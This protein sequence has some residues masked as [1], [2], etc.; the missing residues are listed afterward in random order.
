MKILLLCDKLFYCAHIRQ[1]DSV[2]IKTFLILRENCQSLAQYLKY[3]ALID[4]SANKMKTY[5]V[6][7]KYS[8]EIAAYFSLKAGLISIEN[9]DEERDEFFDTLPGF[10]LANFAVNDSYICKHPHSK[11]LGFVVFTDFISPIVEMAS[12]LI[13]AKILYVFAL[14]YDTLLTHYRQK[15]G[16]TRLDK[17]QEDKLHKRIKNDYD[18]TCIFMYMRI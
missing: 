9:S 11:G 6:R 12:N 13:G 7:D 1:D 10:E 5:L 18:Q 14:P 16:F 2:D 8:N 15:Y 3:E 4:E 17:E